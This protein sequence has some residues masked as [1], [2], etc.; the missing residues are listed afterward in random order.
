[1]IYKDWYIL[2][3]TFY[4]KTGNFNRAQHFW[5]RKLNLREL[6]N[7]YRKNDHPRVVESESNNEEKVE[8][9]LNCLSKDE[10]T[11]PQKK[12]IKTSVSVHLP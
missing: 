9:W 10:K 3:S 1:M 12:N 4:I 8:K 7:L 11:V 6:K 5:R 2:P